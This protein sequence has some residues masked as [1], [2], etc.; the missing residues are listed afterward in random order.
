MDLFFSTIPKIFDK[1]IVAK[2]LFVKY[3]I[4]PTGIVA[5]PPLIVLR[6]LYV[7]VFKFLFDHIWN[8]MC[9]LY[10]FLIDL[11]VRIG[12]FEPKPPR[13]RME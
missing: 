5:L 2:Q 4:V 3:I 6:F 13:A 8:T 12:S 7:H 11:Y 10:L 9:R 1:A